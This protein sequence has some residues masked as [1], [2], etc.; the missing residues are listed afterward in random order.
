MVEWSGW[1]MDEYPINVCRVDGYKGTV[2]FVDVCAENGY[3]NRQW[4]V[5]HGDVVV[6]TGYTLGSKHAYMFCE[7]ALY[8][9][10]VVEFAS[11]MR[12]AQAAMAQVNPRQGGG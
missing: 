10:G 9:A 3:R 5:M 11:M 12:E 8:V 1:T 2:R 6:A 4:E 7:L